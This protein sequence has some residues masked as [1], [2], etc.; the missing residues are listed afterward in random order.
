MGPISVEHATPKTRRAAV[1]GDGAATIC[2]AVCHFSFSV[3]SEIDPQA[4][5]S[6]G[7]TVDPCGWAANGIRWTMEALMKC[8]PSLEDYARLLKVCDSKS[9]SPALGNPI[10]LESFHEASI[11]S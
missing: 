11:L 2:A 1:I 6:L 10:N 9:R 4:V 3:L 5:E 7:F 8:E